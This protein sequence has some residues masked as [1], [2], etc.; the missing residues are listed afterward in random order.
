MYS[1]LNS[2]CNLLNDFMLKSDLKI[3]N[4]IGN[5]HSNL[6]LY[7]YLIQ[8]NIK[9]VFYYD[10]AKYSNLNGEITFYND[11]PVICARYNLWGGFESPTTSRK[12][13]QPT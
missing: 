2:Y 8:E 6:T 7:P 10:Y 9:G 12:N 1:D 13:K 4:I 11:K 5:D 3:V